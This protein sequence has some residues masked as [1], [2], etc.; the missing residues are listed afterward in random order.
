[1][2]RSTRPAPLAMWPSP[3]RLRARLAPI[4]YVGAATVTYLLDRDGRPFATATLTRDHG[5]FSAGMDLLC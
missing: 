2:P 4:G 1:M 3:R 5:H